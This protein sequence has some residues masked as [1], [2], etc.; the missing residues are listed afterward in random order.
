MICPGLT[1]ILPYVATPDAPKE[2]RPV[3][4]RIPR[5]CR[6]CGHRTIHES[7][8]RMPDL[9]EMAL[10]LLTLGLS[11]IASLLA[12]LLLPTRCLGCRKERPPL[13]IKALSRL[14]P[15]GRERRPADLGLDTSLSMMTHEDKVTTR[16]GQIPPT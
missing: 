10:A 7:R 13:V 12:T 11:V 15:F 6:R 5:P 4:L 3:T 2:E 8:I 14:L 1:A 16:S 9:L